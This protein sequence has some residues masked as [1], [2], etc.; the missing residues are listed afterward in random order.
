MQGQM[1]DYN[2]KYWVQRSLL[3]VA[4]GVSAATLNPLMVT[5]AQAAVTSA[6]FSDLV[7]QVTPGVAR[8]N[9]TTNI[10]D[11]ELAQAQTAELLRQFFGDR[12]RLPDRPPTPAIENA[13]GT[14][15]FV[16]AD[17]YMLTNH[18][19]VDGA[20]KITVTLNDRSY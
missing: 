19:V 11:E 13:Y 8:V 20:D 1:A 14:G 7:Q 10:S 9:V 15:F 18:H 5:P 17:G 12:L 3:A 6:D 16:T 4:I 2:L